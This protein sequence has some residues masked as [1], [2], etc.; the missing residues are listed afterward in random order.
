MRRLLHGLL[1]ATL[2]LGACGGDDDDSDRAA[3]TSI[4]E[5]TT[6][7]TSSTTTE[8]RT[9]APDVIPQDESQIT[10]E[11]VEQV[12]DALHE[13][14]LDTIVAAKEAGLVEERALELLTA[15]SSDGVFEQRVND[16][17]DLAANG[18]PG[19]KAEP[20]ALDI[21]VVELHEIAP[22]CVV[23]EVTTD[24][25]RLVESP[26]PVDSNERSFV[27]ILPATDEQLSSGLNPTAWVLDEF[28]VTLDG[29]MAD[30][31]CEGHS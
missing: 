23:A 11:Y 30:L 8:P 21:S 18:F 20:G 15:T 12:L 10:E 19:L 6:S 13:V 31:S 5:E 1:G 29:S 16:L 27:R 3:I 24:A 14:S 26:R 7:S 28:P 17:I 4:P 9:V 25:S 2:L 22:S